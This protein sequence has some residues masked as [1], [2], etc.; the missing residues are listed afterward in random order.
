MTKDDLQTRVQSL[1]KEVA[2]SMENYQRIKAALDNATAAHNSL[3]GRYT[4]ATELLA[5]FDE[6]ST[7]PQT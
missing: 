3:I 1:A 2:E 7:P 6:E 5:K 4:E